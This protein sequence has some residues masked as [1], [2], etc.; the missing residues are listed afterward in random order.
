MYNKT[1]VSLLD[2]FAAQAMA[3]LLRRGDPVSTTDVVTDA[4][5]IAS[6]MVEERQRILA[7]DE[8]DL[9]N[10]DEAEKAFGALVFANTSRNPAFADQFME[11]LQMIYYAFAHHYKFDADE[12]ANIKVYGPRAAD[13]TG[14]IQE[15]AMS[16]G[17]E[18]NR[19]VLTR[20]VGSVAS[21]V[22]T[23]GELGDKETAIRIIKKLYECA[24]VQLSQ[25]LKRR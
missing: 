14:I 2:I 4:Y 11:Y 19:E 3:A 10:P 18:R 5:S 12:R 9:S 23:A 25:P 15:L 17:W 7:E 8:D 21:L 1:E 22:A 24:Q 13:L 16:S 20:A 6:M